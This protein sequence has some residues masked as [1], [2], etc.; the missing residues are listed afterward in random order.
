MKTHALV[1]S[2]MEREWKGRYDEVVLEE[3]V[4]DAKAK[5]GE[6]VEELNGLTCGGDYEEI[7]GKDEKLRPMVLPLRD[8]KWVLS[9]AILLYGSYQEVST[10][11]P[12]DGGWTSQS[13]EK[14]RK[15]LFKSLDAACRSTANKLY[16]A[17]C[18]LYRAV[19]AL[20]LN[21]ILPEM[22]EWMMEYAKKRELKVKG[23]PREANEFI[24]SLWDHRE[25]K[26]CPD[27]HKI[28]QYASLSSAVIYLAAKRN[29]KGRTLTEICDAFG[30]VTLGGKEDTLVRPKFCSKA[31]GEL[32]A[33]LPE[34]VAM[35]AASAPVG[36]DASSAA[37]MPT[38]V[39]SAASSTENPMATPTKSETRI[40]FNDAAPSI[41][42]LS[43]TTS[44]APIIDTS[45]HNIVNDDSSV[46][47]SIVP[48][49]E[50]EAL[51][52]LTSRLAG[53][54]HLPPCAIAASVSIALQCSN[55]A[56]L[57]TPLSTKSKQ[58]IRPPIRRGKGSSSLF[59]KSR[60]AKRAG[61]LS[62]VLKKEGSSDLI[63]AASILLVCMAGQKMQTLARQA[64]NNPS[65]NNLPSKL[66][67]LQEHDEIIDT[68]GSLSNPLDDLTE[69]ISSNKRPPEVETS[70]TSS[71]DP[72]EISPKKQAPIES[73]NAWNHQPPW[74][75]EV[76]QIEQCS[77]V[78]SK[79]IISYYSN[80]LHPRRSHFLD[81]ARKR[82]GEPID[83]YQVSRPAK[84]IKVENNSIENR[85]SDYSPILLQNITVAS[86]MISIRS[87]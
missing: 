48:S 30:T 19:N 15:E 37:A 80:V 78:S 72:S 59:I 21:R 75:R 64:V 82:L 24:L 26:K 46:N 67:R 11:L 27:L 18:L 36:I 39:P 68:I 44:L 60:G 74:H 38:T 35:K 62:A 43:S 51:A 22:S 71:L 5:R 16:I 83:H 56:S 12:R 28:R 79:N 25:W 87:L 6:E 81:V 3:K 7:M 57:S 20:D 13:F 31:M 77:G 8:R 34:V 17:F 45:N 58:Q 40:S 73:W 42:S 69:E 1:E 14:E 65:E 29:G 55:D 52:D 66:E 50:T 76:S 32:R 49:S 86:P 2:M 33:V 4:R 54:L 84:R 70:Q 10:H 9:D 23:I 47:T 61:S 53:S 41:V 63:A 85:S